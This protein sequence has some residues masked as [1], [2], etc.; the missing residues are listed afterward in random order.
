MGGE[1]EAEAMLAECED[2]TV[3]CDC[4]GRRCIDGAPCG[5]G[6]LLRDDGRSVCVCGRATGCCCGGDGAMLIAVGM[7]CVL[8]VQS[9]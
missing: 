2:D 7:V 4:E 1:I 9:L 6:E 8:L 3:L 5:G